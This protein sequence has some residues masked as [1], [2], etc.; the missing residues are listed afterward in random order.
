MQPS[1]I[2]VGQ[3]WHKGC[4]LPN[5]K[6]S[7]CMWFKFQNPISYHWL[8]PNVVTYIK[9]IIKLIKKWFLL[10][11]CTY[12]KIKV[13]LHSLYNYYAMFNN[14]SNINNLKKKIYVPDI[15]MTQKSPC[16]CF[17]VTRATK[18]RSPNFDPNKKITSP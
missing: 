17:P 13:L 15:I 1:F 2:P 6:N 8:N 5:F 7:S 10:I 14:K 3:T 11:H 12:N 18:P 9:R 4:P 16:P